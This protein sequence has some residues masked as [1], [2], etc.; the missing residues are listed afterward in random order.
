MTEP[1]YFLAL[2]TPAKP[3][4]LRE[5][6]LDLLN[7]AAADGALLQQLRRKFPEFISRPE[8]LEKAASLLKRRF[9]DAGKASEWLQAQVAFVLRGNLRLAWRE[10][11]G[12]RR[13]TRLMRTEWPLWAAYDFFFRRLEQNPDE[14]DPH[15]L[16]TAATFYRLFEA[17]NAAVNLQGKFRYCANPECPTP[18]F[19]ERRRGQR[20]CSELCAAHGNRES[21]KKW[22]DKHGKKWR[23]DQK[24][25]LRKKKAHRKG[26]K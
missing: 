8:Q 22:W 7:S 25:K 2:I 17:A 12:L 9:F 1:L 23:R 14:N 13:Q 19:F 3:S 16:A 20:F 24:A 18:F 11:E 26:G 4:R 6:L 21:K 5:F 10:P 15:L